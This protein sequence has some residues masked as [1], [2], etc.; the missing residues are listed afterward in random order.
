MLPKVCP[1]GCAECVCVE[2][3]CAFLFDVIYVVL[4]A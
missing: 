3:V 1:S 2:S 4:E